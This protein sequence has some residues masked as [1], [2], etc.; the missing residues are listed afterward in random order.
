[1]ILPFEWCLDYHLIYESSP[2]RKSGRFARIIIIIIIIIIN[3]F[4]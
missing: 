3:R 1:M 4:V 2:K